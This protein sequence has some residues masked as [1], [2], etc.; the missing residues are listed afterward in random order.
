M[1]YDVLII[2]G[3]AAGFFTA[4]N[5][6][7]HNPK[8]KIAILEK[9]KEGLTKV[10][11]SGGGRCN[12]TN[13]TY[14]ANKLVENYPRGH[15]E[16]LGPFQR[17]KCADTI[18]WFEQHGVLLKIEEDARVFPKSD[19]SQTIVD[20]FINTAHQLGI[21]FHKQH[22]V[23]KIEKDNIWQITTEKEIYTATHL[24]ITTGSNPKMWALLQK[25]GHSIVPPVP[26]LF[27]FCCDNPLIHSLSGTVA[28]VTLRL[29]DEQNI[30]LK[31]R[32][33]PIDKGGQK[34]MMLI[35]H[36]GMSGP[37]ILRLSAWGARVLAEKEY[38]FRLLIDWIPE[39]NEEMVQKTLQK[40]KQ[41]QPKQQVANAKI[42]PIAKRLWKSIV[43]ESGIPQET[44][45]ATLTKVQTQ[46]LCKSLK[47]TITNIN[48]KAT[49]K[50]EFVT[51]GGIKLSEI[52]F[53]TYESN[54]FP[55]LYFAGEVMDIDAITGGF[56]FQ[57]AWTGG[58][59]VA[60]TI[61]NKQLVEKSKTLA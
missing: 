5:C 18:Q 3:G 40:V 51:A 19:N 25:M 42:F 12:V 7:E 30:P 28:K 11:I 32:N 39:Q 33:I 9:G 41:S 4:I 8:L 47:K 38:R 50:E 52:N 49:F 59:H 43:N 54:L 13:A 57:N 35:T 16:L 55:N 48:G 27:T 44:N 34:G 53:K 60:Q 31:E 22:N 29:L 23:Q 20:C 58:Y 6:A 61:A 2:G 36:W 14:S 15:R 37:V 24:V 56:N 10:R 17:F 46:A 1:H 26:S 45:W 21:K